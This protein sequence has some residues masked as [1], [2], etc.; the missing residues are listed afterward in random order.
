MEE[1]LDLLVYPLHNVRP[2]EMVSCEGLVLLT[3]EAINM[4]RPCRHHSQQ[5]A[6][7][8]EV[9]PGQPHIFSGAVAGILSHGYHVDALIQELARFVFGKLVL[10]HGN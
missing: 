8:S 10:A 9:I 5:G 2:K 7:R 6:F 3:L 4:T 1:D